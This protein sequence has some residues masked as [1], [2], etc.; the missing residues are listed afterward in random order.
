MQKSNEAISDTKLK[1]IEDAIGY[2]YRDRSF[3]T[4]AITHSS[5][6]NEIKSNKLNSNE[7]IEF[8]GD[9]V[10]NIAISEYIYTKY[11]HLSEGEMTKARASIVCEGSLVNSANAINLKE[12][13]LLGKGEEVSGGRNRASILSD[14]FE[15]I[16][17]SIYLDGG[18]EPAKKFIYS[19]MNE[20]I[21]TAIKGDSFVDYKTKLQELAQKKAFQKIQYEIIEEKG[22]DHDKSFEIQ[23]KIGDVAMGTGTGKSKKEAEQ[24]AAK[25]AIGRIQ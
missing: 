6:A 12:Y 20:I 7:R 22:P 8:L 11:S 3:L 9:A 14:A 15:A 21:V 25:V 10:L 13:L 24:N 17:G 18:F 2:C 1:F 19:I 23:V 5:F 4:L 16:I